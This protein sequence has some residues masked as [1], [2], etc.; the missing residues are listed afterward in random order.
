VEAPDPCVVE[1]LEPPPEA[2]VELCWA[3]EEPPQA[4]ISAALASV[5]IHMPP[6]FLDLATALTASSP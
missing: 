1:A 5:P 4:A 2:G 6:C 3:G